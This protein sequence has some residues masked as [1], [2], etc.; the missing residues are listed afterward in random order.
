M[1]SVG[2]AL[3]EAE[4]SNGRSVPSLE[5]A[6]GFQA[7]AQQPPCNVDTVRLSAKSSLLLPARRLPPL[8]VPG[9]PRPRASPQLHAEILLQKRRAPSSE[10]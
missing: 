5:Q 8:K 4:S 1:C 10:G 7:S 3:F 6:D 9:L 2:V